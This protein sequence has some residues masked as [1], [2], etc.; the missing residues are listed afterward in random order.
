MTQLSLF[1]ETQTAHP[2]WSDEHVVRAV[3]RQL[4]AQGEIEPPVDVEL[5]ASLCGIDAIEQR[6]GGPAGMLMH[7]KRGWVASVS[8][9]DGWERQRFTILQEGGHTLLPGFARDRSYHRCAG[10]RTREE[11]LCDLAAAELLFPRACFRAD[12][13]EAGF[14]CDGVE[15]LAEAY[16][17]SRQ[18]TALR[19]V[20]VG[21]DEAALLVFSVAHKP[22]EHG[23]EATCAP[24]LRLEWAHTSGDWPYARQHKSVARGTPFARAWDY[25]LVDETTEVTEVFAEPVGALDVSARRYGDKVLALLRPP[26]RLN[27]R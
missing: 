17:A 15:A 21:P 20:D 19:V 25:E 23:R 24:K 13:A 5:V 14:G 22:A 3:C 12:L 4:L 18:A 9:D 11:Q 7:T 10:V 27:V 26:R 2:G 6:S 1:E 16:V 8:S